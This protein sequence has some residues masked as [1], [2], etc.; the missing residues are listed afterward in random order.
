[1]ENK[2]IIENIG[3]EFKNRFGYPSKRVTFYDRK[4]KLQKEIYL[5][6]GHAGYYDVWRKIEKNGYKSLIYGEIKEITINE[7][8][9]RS[10]R[11]YKN[12]EILSFQTHGIFV[13][14]KY[15]DLTQ[16][17]NIQMALKNQL[18]QYVNSENELF[19]IDELTEDEYLIK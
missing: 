9:I 7:I 4:S 2:L 11:A 15:R 6:R 14:F 1:M 19:D 3:E 8:I 13:F 5:H 18:W 16:K 17:G 12:A 10:I